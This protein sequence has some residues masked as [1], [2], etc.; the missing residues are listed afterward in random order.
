MN[1]SDPEL[2]ARTAHGDRKAFEVFVNRWDAPLGRFLQKVAAGAQ[3]D[4]VRNA[5]FLRLYSRASQY[6]GGSVK[7]WIFK[8]AWRLAQNARRNATNVRSVSLDQA[9]ESLDRAP[10]PDA[11]AM[12]IEEHARVR[13]SFVM[14]DSRDRALLWLCI[15]EA[16][17][18][19]Q[20]A[21]VF[22]EPPSTL[23]YQ[24]TKALGRIRKNLTNSELSIVAEE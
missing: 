5:T 3:A 23:R 6:R 24:F 11:S 17:P 12:D 10:R 15:V 16:M 2:L 18:L 4:D 8:T 14:L 9:G 7:A 20:V 19:E 22:G 21:R 1:E 13:A